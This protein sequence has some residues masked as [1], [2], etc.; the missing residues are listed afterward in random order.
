[1]K[2]TYRDLLIKLLSTIENIDDEAVVE[3]Y[4]REPDTNIVLKK[5]IAPIRCFGFGLKVEAM[6]L[7]ASDRI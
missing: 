2:I 5:E 1:M 6:E 7:K 3:I 4:Y